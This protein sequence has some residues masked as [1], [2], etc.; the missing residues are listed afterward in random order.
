M[1]TPD[2]LLMTRRLTL[3]D[4]GLTGTRTLH[5]VWIGLFGVA[6]FTAIAALPAGIRLNATL[7]T[8]HLPD[9]RWSVADVQDALA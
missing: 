3:G 6:A 9:P 8:L 2:F 5:R 7:T 4:S 1:E